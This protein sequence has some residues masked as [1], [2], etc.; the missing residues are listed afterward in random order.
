MSQTRGRGS[1]S[2]T[3]P[4]SRNLSVHFF[5]FFVA[6][7]SQ[8]K[9]GN[10][11]K[12]HVYR[13]T[14]LGRSDLSDRLSLNLHLPTLIF[15]PLLHPPAPPPLHPPPHRVL[16]HRQR[17]Q[18]LPG[19]ACGA[20]THPLLHHAVRHP[21]LRDGVRLRRPLGGLQ[22]GHH[23]QERLRAFSRRLQGECFSNFKTRTSYYDCGRR[24]F[25]IMH[26]LSSF[27]GIR[28]NCVSVRACV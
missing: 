3:N 10:E 23:A 22:H 15:S 18:D 26:G 19:Q 8:K 24:R 14:Q 20:V 28:W 2:P 27:V 21:S 5:I 16:R 13:S 6:S 12:P 7:Q 17:R 9:R 4:A 11:K 1:P 25:S